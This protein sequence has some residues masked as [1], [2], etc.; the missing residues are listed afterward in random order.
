[1][2]LSGKVVLGLVVDET[3]KVT[4]AAPAGQGARQDFA[5]AAIRAVRTWTFTPA[6]KNGVPVK[7]R[8]TVRIEF[9]P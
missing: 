1:M 8:I 4:E 7:T 3:G 2:R 6:T 9:N 5:A